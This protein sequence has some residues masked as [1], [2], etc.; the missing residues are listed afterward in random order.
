MGGHNYRFKNLRDRDLR[1]TI[2]RDKTYLHPSRLWFFSLSQWRC[3][4]P[5]CR[6]FADDHRCMGPP[7][8]RC[9]LL[10]QEHLS[11]GQDPNRRTRHSR[12]VT[13]DTRSMPDWSYSDWRYDGFGRRSTRDRDVGAEHQSSCGGARICQGTGRTVARRPVLLRT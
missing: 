6:V 2:W 1:Q 13:P 8:R 10:E 3:E 7:R 9:F 11:L 4:H 5:R 12:P